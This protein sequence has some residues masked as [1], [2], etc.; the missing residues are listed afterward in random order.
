MPDI[1][2]DND[3]FFQQNETYLKRRN[4]LNYSNKLMTVCCKLISSNG[5]GLSYC[6]P[7]VDCVVVQR[8][9]WKAPC[10]Q[11]YWDVCS[12]LTVLYLQ[13]IP[14]NTKLILCDWS[15]LSVCHC[16]ISLFVR[17]VSF[18]QT[19]LSWH[20]EQYWAPLLWQPEKLESQT[21]SAQKGKGRTKCRSVA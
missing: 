10:H 6:Q 16:S 4:Y 9:E 17:S 12:A 21:Y 15:W 5:P 7:Q 13:Q 3:A 1:S 19:K 8:F 20:P 2:W 14:S 11:Y 18:R